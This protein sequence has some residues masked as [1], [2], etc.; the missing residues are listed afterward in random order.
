MDPILR[1]LIEAGNGDEEVEVILKLRDDGVVPPDVRLVTRFRDIAT[2]RLSRNQIRETW[3]HP[4]VVSVKGSRYVMAEP[5]LVESDGASSSA[6]RVSASRRPAALEFTGRGVVVGFVDW[7]CDFAHPNFCQDNGSTRL[8]AL[9]DQSNTTSPVQATPY[10]YG[11]FYFREDIN[12]ALECPDP[13]EAL[14][15]HPAKADPL[16][17]GAH[18]THV[19]DIAVGNGRVPGSPMG[20]APEAEIVFVHLAARGIEGLANLGHSVRILEALDFI[21]K[22]AGA[23]PWV[24]NLSLGQCGGPHT[25]LTLVEQGMDALLL[26]APGQC[27]VGSAGNYFNERTH[28]AGQLRPGQ[29]RTL[30]W[31]TDKADIT[32]NELEVWYSGYDV[33]TVEVRAPERDAVFRVTLGEQCSIQLNSREVGRIYHRA[34]DPS[35]GDHHIDIFLYPAAPAGPWRVTLVGEDI[36]DGR[37][38]AWVERDSACLHCQSRFDPQDAISSGTTGTLANG[39]HTIAVGAYDHHSPAMDVAPFSSCGPTRDGRQKPDLIAPG[40]SILAARSAPRD[41]PA[42]PP[43]LTTMSGTSM[44]APHVTGTVACM[45]QAARRPLWIRET[46]TL[47]LGSTQT[48]SVPEEVAT[49]IGDGYLDIQRAVDAASRI[50]STAQAIRSQPPI[51]YKP[52]LL[53]SIQEQKEVDMSRKYSD[54]WTEASKGEFS[55]A[56]DDSSRDE[57]LD[58]EDNGMVFRPR[59]DVF[60]ADEADAAEES[61]VFGIDVSHHQGTVNWQ[62][63]AG[64]GVIYTWIKATEG[65]T[66]VDDKFASNWVDSKAAG[67]L[68]GAYHFFRP[69]RD[70]EQ[71]AK[72]FV[73]TIRAFSAGSKSA[74]EPGDL[75]PVLDIEVTDGKSSQEILDSIAT[76]LEVVEQALGR[77]P[78]I[79]TYPAFWRDAL[80]NPKRF[81]AYALWIAHYTKARQPLVPGGWTTWTFWQYLSMGRVQG[82]GTVVDLNRFKGSLHDLRLLAG[83]TSGATTS[84]LTTAPAESTASAGNGSN[85]NIAGWQPA[86]DDDGLTHFGSELVDLADDLVSAAEGPLSADTLLSRVL[87]QIGLTDT[88]SG[89]GTSH[90]PAAADIF[91]TLAYGANPMLRYQYRQ[92]FEVIAEP[93]SRLDRP[94]QPGDVLVRRAVA[95]DKLGYIAF[96]TTGQLWRD[97]QAKSMGLRIESER[98]GWYVEVIDG[99]AEPHTRTD[100]FARRLLDTNQRLQPDQ[101]VLRL[102]YSAL[103][104][105]TTYE[106]VEYSESIEEN[107]LQW[108]TLLRGTSLSAADRKA[109]FQAV[110]E[111]RAAIEIHKDLHYAFSLRKP[112]PPPYHQGLVYSRSKKDLLAGVEPDPTNNVEADPDRTRI[113]K[114]AWREVLTEGSAAS[115]NTY[116]SQMWTI[117]RGLG[118][119]GGQGLEV[120]ETVFAADPDARNAMVQVGLAVE[121]GKVLALNV[122]DET[123]L[124]GDVALHHIELNKAIFSQFIHTFQSPAHI[125]AMVNAQWSVLR[126]NAANIPEQVFKGGVWTWT[127]GKGKSK[128]TKMKTLVP[129]DDDVILF[130]VH[131]NHFAPFGVSWSRMIRYGTDASGKGDVVRIARLV[132]PYL[133]PK[134]IHGEAIVFPNEET[135][136][137]EWGNHVFRNM[138]EPAKPLPADLETNPAWF[139]KVGRLYRALQL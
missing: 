120:L 130:G 128:V 113:N 89:P 23:K 11:V 4:A 39:F 9:W 38:H 37:F 105:S 8:L 34:H 95:E 3:E 21:A 119:K 124:Q 43:R 101:M 5:V 77:K 18:G 54:A 13:Y 33:L 60:E 44:A 70:A 134:E 45:F 6:Y 42:F 83:V 85:V 87:Q 79:Y 58:E 32:P 121:G 115:I 139:F 49:R 53:S 66:Y 47:L 56:Q 99:G 57:V 12:R 102:I 94:L 48:V 132:G 25:G 46:R 109:I 98:P 41:L 64:A 116:D 71:Q 76:W 65:K 61:F 112:V 31:W 108:P 88:V 40:V 20:I 14:G 133:S 75:P 90:F 138:L 52:V 111:N 22:V 122:D 127:E 107:V 72:H 93:G 2:C 118:V 35:N 1:Q 82:I 19:C 91:D 97:D 27:I 67:F 135:R 28:A 73:E 7:G 74:L 36:V 68:R 30:T 63:V 59:P 100:F 137:L 110:K 84:L 131:A 86:E 104:D 50:G 17:S 129:W 81:A 126:K 125:Q 69:N 123:V 10:G 55:E 103:P 106:D 51:S 114:L 78:I 92:I 29:E 96:L 62:A 26:Q 24:A 136:I 117:G 80:G 15:Y 16:G